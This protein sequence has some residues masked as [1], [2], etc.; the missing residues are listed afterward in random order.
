MLT[1][2]EIDRIPATL[3]ANL[4][5]LPLMVG[6]SNGSPNSSFLNSMLLWLKAFHII[7]MVTWFAGLFYLPRLFVYHV[8]V[9]TDAEQARFVTMEKRL[10][11]MMSIGM[12]LTWG[13]GIWLLTL[14][15]GYMSQGWMHAKLA[16][17]LALSGYQGWLKS[18]LRKFANGANQRSSTFWRW[19]NEFPT[20]I[21]LAVVILVV[22]KPF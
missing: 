4:F 18:N 20:V 17:V 13:L 12:I 1:K 6:Y 7:A 19:A 3:D 21:L 22:I 15:P 10:Y 8:D 14:F 11:F 16:L 2:S 5:S 9:S